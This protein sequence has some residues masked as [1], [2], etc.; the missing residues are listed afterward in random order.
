MKQVQPSYFK[1][2]RT[3]NSYDLDF[4]PLP[5]SPGVYI[6]VACDVCCYTKGNPFV[7]DILYVGMSLRLAQRCNDSHEVFALLCEKYDYVK[8]F[9]KSLSKDALRETEKCLIQELHPPYNLAHRI[10]GEP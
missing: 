1:S 4:S 6:F 2:W 9:F 8:T 5:N 10:K 3:P 7:Y